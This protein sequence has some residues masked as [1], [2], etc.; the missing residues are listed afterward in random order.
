VISITVFK[1]ACNCNWLDGRLETRTEDCADRFL[2]ARMKSNQNQYLLQD[3]FLLMASQKVWVSDPKE[4]FILGHIVDLG[5]DKVTVEPDP[6]P[7]HRTR[8]SASVAVPYD[9]VYP[10]E[11]NSTEDY[12]DNCSL[13]YLN[14]ATLLNNV[15][16]R[17]KRN[18]IY[19]NRIILTL[20]RIFEFS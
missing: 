9:Y 13:M 1:F 15:R 12:D 4:G 6:P 10:A 14:E 8:A 2:P 19:V 3:H 7:G 17:Y 5:S 18:Q 16:L 20:E 11:D